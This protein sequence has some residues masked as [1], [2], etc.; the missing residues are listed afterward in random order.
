MEIFFLSM[1]LMSAGFVALFKDTNEKVLFY[2]LPGVLN[3]LIV[4]LMVL[5]LLSV[6]GQGMRLLGAVTLI[7]WSFIFLL[8]LFRMRSEQQIGSYLWCTA[9]VLLSANA[10]Q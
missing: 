7:V 5:G 6:H 8:M 3:I 1:V 10:L 9:C 2:F 4:L